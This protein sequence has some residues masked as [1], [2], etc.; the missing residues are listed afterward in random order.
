[1]KHL[2]KLGSVLLAVIALPAMGKAQGAAE[3][4]KAMP[5]QQTMPAPGTTGT[6][7]AKELTLE[8]G[9]ATGLRA[10]PQITVGKLVAL[11]AHESVRE[12]R[13]ALMPQVNLNLSGIGADPGSRLSAGYLTDGRMYSRA[14]GGVEVSQLITDF[15]RTSEPGGEFPISGE[16]G[17]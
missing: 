10:N 3:Q 7:T 16:S 14:A 5:A 4:A 8:Q 17:G 6:S 2:M 11:Q 15:G 13:S 9:E 12:T 1:M